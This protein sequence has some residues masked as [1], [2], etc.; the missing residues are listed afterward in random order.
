VRRNSE[1]I[2]RPS[3]KRARLCIELPRVAIQQELGWSQTKGKSN[4]AGILGGGIRSATFNLGVIQA[5]ARAE[6]LRTFDYLSTVS[7]GGYIGAWLFGWMHHQNLS[8]TDMEDRLS[9]S[10]ADVGESADIPEVHFLREYSNYLTPKKG[11]LSPDS[12]AFVNGYV[13]NAILNQIILVLGL[14]SILLVP[15]CFVTFLNL[16]ETL[17]ESSHGKFPPAIQPLMQA[18]Y[19]AIALGL[20]L[21]LLAVLYIAKNEVMGSI[22]FSRRSDIRWFMKERWIVCL[23]VLPAVVASAFFAYG[24]GDF[25]LDLKVTQYPR[26]LYRA[27]VVGASLYFALWFLT[28]IVCVTGERKRRRTNVDFEPLKLLLTA[29]LAGAITGYLLIP[30][31]GILVPKGSPTGMVSNWEVATLGT[32]LMVGVMLLTGILHIGFMGI[33]MKDSRREWWGRVGGWFGI[34]AVCWFAL[35]SVAIYFPRGLGYLWEHLLYPKPL[36]LA[37]VLAW[38]GTTVYGLA[39]GK[40][41]ETFKP[42]IEGLGKKRILGLL[43]RISPVVFILGLFL[44]LSILASWISN[45]VTG[46]TGNLLCMPRDWDCDPLLFVTCLAAAGAAV[47]VA[48]RVDV[49]QFSVHGLYRNRLVRCYLGATAKERIAEPSTGFCEK[50]DF[51]LS[52]LNDSKSGRP[53]PIINTSLNIVRGDDLA[54][55]TR[56]ARSFAF[57]P[58][59]AGFTRHEEGKG[60]WESFFAPPVTCGDEQ[61]DGGITLGTCMAISGAAASP[62][63]GA[64][65]DPALGFLMSLFD[66]RLGWWIVSVRA[67]H[68]DNYGCFA[69]HAAGVMSAMR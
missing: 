53:I 66:V 1:F 55:Q 26:S 15:R 30:L 18:Q 48:W 25:L 34:Y 24:L 65:S 68:D 4:R 61:Q 33:G 21:T 23:I 51:P 35:F 60:K 19:F 29:A 12:W 32:P 54:L 43:A 63:M 59:L 10:V 36:T 50:D 58:M 38:I 62:N 64:Y 57:T 6:L 42:V 27:P 47:L 28:L 22:V 9:K 13:R 5:L 52:S 14:I 31:A 40:S 20:A 7:G 16:L 17:E 8:I 67:T 69:A 56:K 41:A 37:G 46:S 2:R 11:V 45:W 44:G 49:N 3:L 39:F